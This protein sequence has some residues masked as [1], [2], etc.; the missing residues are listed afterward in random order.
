MPESLLNK[1]FWLWIGVALLVIVLDQASKQAIEAA[2]IY[3]EIKPVIPG[4]FNLTLAYN[5]GAAFSFLAD[6]GGW[7]RHFFTVLALAVSVFIINVLRK[8]YGETRLSLALALIMGGALGNVIDRVAF[9]HVIDFI[10]I[11]YGIRHYPSFNIADSA[12]CIGAALLVLD[13]FRGKKKE[14]A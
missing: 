5:P 8:H 9:G 3:G 12:I 11:Y 14:Q 10:D 4:F 2:F 1:R 6:A 7:Q 13:S